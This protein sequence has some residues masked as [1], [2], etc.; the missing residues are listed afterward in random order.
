LNEINTYK[1][2]LGKPEGDSLLV[3]L[4][5]IIRKTIKMELK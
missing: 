5:R 4:R 1:F 3:T 2:V